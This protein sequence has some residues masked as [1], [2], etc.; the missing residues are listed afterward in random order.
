M[1]SSFPP[2]HILGSFEQALESLRSSVL[3]MAGLALRGLENAERGLFER[4]TEACQAAI[5]DDEEIDVLEV[6]IDRDGVDALMK[7]HPVARDMRQIISAMKMSSNLERIGDHAVG[8]A[9]RARKLNQYPALPEV[10][11]LRPMFRLAVGMV[12]DAVTAYA[13]GNVECARGMK[14]R[15]RELDLANK[16]ITNLL[17]AR[18]AERVEELRGYLN[19]IFIARILERIGDHATNLC[20]DVVFVQ[21]AQDIRHQPLPAG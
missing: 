3:M 15:D 10:E 7:F 9:R 2:R 20:E 4:D 12:S 14:A 1:E 17:A 5:A 21:Q 16:N 6:Q 18:M 11:A 13:D 19:L 8:V